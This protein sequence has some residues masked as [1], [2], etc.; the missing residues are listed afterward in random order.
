MWRSDNLVQVWLVEDG[1]EEWIGIRKSQRRDQTRICRNTI[2]PILCQVVLPTALNQEQ[3][4]CRGDAY[5][6]LSSH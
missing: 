2:P 5:N 4:T 3:N 1:P 6:K